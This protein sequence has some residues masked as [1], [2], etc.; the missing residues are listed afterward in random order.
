MNK[1]FSVFAITAILT[2]PAIAKVEKVIATGT[3]ATEYEATVDA[4][5]NAIRQNTNVSVDGGSGKIVNVKHDLEDHRKAQESHSGSVS[6]SSSFE[7]SS[8]SSENASSGSKKKWWQFWRKSETSASAE[9]SYKES[10][11]D[12]GS[13]DVSSHGELS[14]AERDINMK[15]KG[16]IEGY[17]VLEMK[18]KGKKYTAKIEAKVF[19]VDDYVSPDMVKKSQYRVVISDF[20][21]K[22]NWDCMNEK[23]IVKPLQRNLVKSKKITMVDRAN[24][25]KQMK[26][27]GLL[28]KDIANRENQSKLKQVAIADYI[29]VGQ[30]ESFNI[31]RTEKDIALT[32]EHISKTDISVTV[33]YKLIETATMDIVSS[34]STKQSLHFDY[35]AGCADA[36]SRLAERAAND[37]SSKM[38]EDLF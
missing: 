20:E 31:N 30:I 2:L 23:M 11:N 4:I 3:G 12:K 13:S 6:A 36:A 32:G 38:L 16:Q 9:S 26:E 17:K 35:R 10:Y 8:S 22:R 19:V 37:L 5:D 28:N 1:I 18:Q 15:Y 21:G 27:L 33:S 14:Y 25:D 24:F 34:D 7:A 29:L